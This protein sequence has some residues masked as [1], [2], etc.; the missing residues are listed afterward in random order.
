MQNESVNFSIFSVECRMSN[1]EC[2]FICLQ[3]NFQRFYFRMPYQCFYAL[4]DRSTSIGLCR[5]T[6]W[7]VSL[8]H[9]TVFIHWINSRLLIE[10]TMI[11][12][13]MLWCLRIVHTQYAIRKTSW[14]ERMNEILCHNHSFLFSFR[15]LYN[16]DRTVWQTTISQ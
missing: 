7:I 16:Y 1:V 9:C 5:T 10:L 12:H 13:A 8:T 4:Y 3:H 2:R 6:G 15:L 11:L 14:F